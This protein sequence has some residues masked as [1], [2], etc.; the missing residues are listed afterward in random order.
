MGYDRGRRKGRDKRDNIGE[1]SFD[2]FG[3]GGNFGGDRG[4]DRGNYGGGGDRGGYGGGGGNR[5]GYGGGGG[6]GGSFQSG[7]AGGDGQI[8]LTYE[9]LPLPQCSA[10]FDPSDGI[11][12]SVPVEQRLDLSVFDPRAPQQWPSNNVIPAGSHVYQSETFGNNVSGY[13]VAGRA[14]VLSLIHI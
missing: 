11:T 4:G 1:D 6:G 8:R 12:E 9:V 7:G 13:T 3:G 14:R 2:P 5:G 10:I